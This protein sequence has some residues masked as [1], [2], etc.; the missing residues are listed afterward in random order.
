MKARIEL[1]GESRGECWQQERVDGAANEGEHY[2]FM[3][4][5]RTDIFFISKSTIIHEVQ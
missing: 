1:S 5:E 2:T 3:K 4:A